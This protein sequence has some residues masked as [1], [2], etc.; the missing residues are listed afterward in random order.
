MN[1][2]TQQPRTCPDCG[3]QLDALG[4]CP[5]AEP[6]QVVRQTSPVHCGKAP[7]VFALAE[8]LKQ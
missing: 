6:R 5:Q 3:E 1:Q 4:I 2:P 8:Y 7:R